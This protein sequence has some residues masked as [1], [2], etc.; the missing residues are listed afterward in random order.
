VEAF[1]EVSAS[2]LRHQSDVLHKERSRARFLHEPKELKYKRVARI[3]KVSAALLLAE[4]LAWRPTCQEIDLVHASLRTELGTR[5][6]SSVGLE[7]M[8]P[9]VLLVRLDGPAVVIEC[10]SHVKPARRQTDAE[11]TGS[12]ECVNGDQGSLVHACVLSA[13]TS[14]YASVIHGTRRV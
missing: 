8:G 13:A 11:A 3:A 9:E 2:H 14:N 1:N 10:R 6:A 7:S 5:H 4:S 12:T